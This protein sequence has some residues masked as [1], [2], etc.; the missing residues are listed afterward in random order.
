VDI[1]MSVVVQARQNRRAS[2]DM[3]GLEIALFEDHGAAKV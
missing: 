1:A 3:A 2:S